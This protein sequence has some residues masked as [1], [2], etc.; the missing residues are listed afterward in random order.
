LAYQQGE[1]W[2]EVPEERQFTGNFGGQGFKLEQ[3]W[4]SFT[5][6]ETKIRAFYKDQET[7]WFTYYRKDL[8]RE[9]PLIF[10]FTAKDEVEKIN[11]KWQSKGGN[12]D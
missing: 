4:I 9:R 12:H 2:Y 7:P 6:Y 10:T 8:P 11:G 5:I 3:G 1:Y